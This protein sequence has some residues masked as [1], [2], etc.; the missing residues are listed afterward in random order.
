MKLEARLY[1]SSNKGL[2]VGIISGLHIY[3]Y[4]YIHIYIYTY[5]HRLQCPYPRVFLVEARILEDLDPRLR[6]LDSRLHLY[7]H[8]LRTFFRVPTFQYANQ[9]TR[10]PTNGV[11]YD[12]RPLTLQG[13]TAASPKGPQDSAI[14]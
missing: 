4:T 1:G 10:Y 8:T 7:S 2:H 6:T 12:L 13:C 14:R 11:G 5:I 3:I 9:K